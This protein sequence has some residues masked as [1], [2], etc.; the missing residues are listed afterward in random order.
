[1]SKLGVINGLRGCAILCVIFQ[2]VFYQ[3][4]VPGALAFDIFSVKILP[5][6]YLS[7]GWLGV[8]LFF[9]LSGFVLAYPYF[10]NT[11]QLASGSDIRRFYI[12]RAKRLLP[13]Y[14]FSLVI[15][16]IFVVR[17]G[18]LT[19][20]LGEA[21]LLVTATFNFSSEMY[22]PRYNWVLWSLGIEIWFSIVFP[23]LLIAVNRYGIVK[24]LI[25]V[26]VVSLATRLVGN[27]EAFYSGNPTLNP[28]K[29]SLLGRLDE[30][31]WGMFLCY[32]YV[33][34]PKLM[35][36]YNTTL[37]FLLGVFL[38]TAACFLW[39]YVRLDLLGTNIVPFINLVVDVGFVLLAM[40]LLVMKN[41]P[42]KWLFSNYFIQ[43]MGVMCYSLYV[44]HGVAVRKIISSYDIPHI[45]RYF[46]LVFLLSALSYR[47]IEFGHRADTK[48][49]FLLKSS[50]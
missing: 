8:N 44:W 46:V 34:K 47:Y 24:V 5:L 41:G 45:V 21:L 33:H 4:A 42:I 39:D 43:L 25:A 23:F 14:Y 29:D 31:V 38:V 36:R 22:F 1:M 17:P 50:S 37:V 2:H 10:L 13:L 3:V 35:E 40:S 32:L 16:I 7:N 26:L 19:S 49:L 20:F 27:A 15:C 12:R 6:T 30:F 28:V 11:R 48:R 18:S 9:I